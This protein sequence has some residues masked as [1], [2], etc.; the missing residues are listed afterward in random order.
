MVYSTNLNPTNNNNNLLND[1]NMQN[2]QA[3]NEISTNSLNLKF[4]TTKSSSKISSFDFAKGDAPSFSVK[5][6]FGTG[7]QFTSKTKPSK[8]FLKCNFKNFSFSKSKSDNINK[9]G[10][11][12][13]TDSFLFKM[14]RE[15]NKTNQNEKNILQIQ[16]IKL[17]LL[18]SNGQNKKFFST[19]GKG[20][21]SITEN[22][23]VY[24]IIVR[25]NKGNC[26][27]NTRIFPNII[28]KISNNF[29]QIVGQNSDYI[30]E[31]YGD[32]END[33]NKDSD[34]NEKESILSI[35]RIKFPSLE[36]AKEF[37]QCISLI[38]K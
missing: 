3:E 8:E 31:D 24:R 4:D 25:N 38:K 27:L 20:R 23:N 21:I 22:N 18:S 5:F 2:N 6:N 28:P 36:K 37:Y 29:V 30:N 12:D 34:D 16:D 15:S 19:V 1:K 13:Y 9:K 32:A 26:I 14:P 17:Y 35:Y 11:F 7:K 33:D 10:G